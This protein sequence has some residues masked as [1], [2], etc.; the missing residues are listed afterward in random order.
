MHV[1]TWWQRLANK[2]WNCKYILPHPR[3][4][5]HISSVSGERLRQKMEKTLAPVLRDEDH[6][7]HSV[8]LC[9]PSLLSAENVNYRSHL[10]V[11]R[12]TEHGWPSMPWG[13]CCGWALNL[14]GK[15]WLALCPTTCTSL[16]FRYPNFPWAPCLLYPWITASLRYPQNWSFPSSPPISLFLSPDLIMLTFM[17]NR[18][19]RTVL[20]DYCP[21]VWRWSMRKGHSLS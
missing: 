3:R 19:L 9:P 5:E 4:M 1:H 10:L 20:R 6:G 13:S 7:F 15:A 2:F 17:V 12:V 14:M 16:N 8:H 18:I 21:C 11:I